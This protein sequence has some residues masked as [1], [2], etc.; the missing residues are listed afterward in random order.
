[1][2]PFGNSDVFASGQAKYKYTTTWAAPREEK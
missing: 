1:M 2:L